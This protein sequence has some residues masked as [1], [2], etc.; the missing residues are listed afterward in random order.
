MR[1][2]FKFRKQ[3]QLKKLD[4]S[5]KQSWDKK[6]K[7]LCNKINKLENYY[8][9]SSCSGRILLIKD[10]KE[11]KDNLFVKVW[12]K[13]IIKKE[14]EK[15][16]EKLNKK[17]LIYFKQDPCILHIACKTLEDAQKLHDIAKIS[18]WKRCGIIAT[19]KRFV[20]ELNGTG[21][22]EFPIY[23]NQILV[24]NKFILEIIKQS[25]KKLKES[26]KII[27]KLEKK[28]NSI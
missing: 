1:D 27:N 5:L 25:N 21:K 6:I 22:L 10:C 8:T 17:N 16:L 12:H 18:G 7:K 4:K 15:E 14:L 24:E 13:T 26:W 2:Q 23:K 3:N 28:L 20:L 11:K 9:T 19:K